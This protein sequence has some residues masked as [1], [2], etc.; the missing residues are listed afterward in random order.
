MENHKLD[1]Y[2]TAYINKKI[3]S[4]WIVDLKIKGKTI[5]DGR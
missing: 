3:N 5:K 2:L 1:P 4:I